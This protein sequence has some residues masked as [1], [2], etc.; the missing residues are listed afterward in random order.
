M[1][2]DTTQ[3]RIQSFAFVISA[4]IAVLLCVWLA[5]SDA[6][7][8]PRLCQFELDSRINPNQASAASLVRLPGIGIVRAGAIVSYRRN[9]SDGTAF[10]NSDDLQKIRGIGP[11]TAE[12]ISQW[13]KF[14]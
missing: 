7:S 14:E 4:G 12:A 13:L 5:V 11:K 1:N 3:S 2:T 8:P 9:H 6:S 10:E